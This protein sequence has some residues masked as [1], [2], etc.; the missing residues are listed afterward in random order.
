[1]GSSFQ[2]YMKFIG[3]NSDA[4]VCRRSTETDEMDAANVADVKG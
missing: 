3:D 2:T 1:M 4:I